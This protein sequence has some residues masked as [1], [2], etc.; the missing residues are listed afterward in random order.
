MWNSAA[1]WRKFIGEPMTEYSFE[2]A[3]LR[4]RLAAFAWDYLVILVYVLVTAV[5][6]ITMWTTMGPFPQTPLWLLDIIA[7][8]TMVLPVGLYFVLQECS[9]RQATWGKRRMGLQVML[10]DGR[11]LSLWRAVVRTAVKFL[12]WQ[13]AHI[14]IYRLVGLDEPPAWTTYGLILLWILVGAYLL[15]I[16]ATRNHQAPYDWLA[17]SV[18][19]IESGH[20]RRGLLSGS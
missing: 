9:P 13:I 2:Y 3:G 4:L 12:P 6:G 5:I 1:K 20:S 7:F 19:I 8:A 16:A 17:G 18:V 14:V 10:V 15:S 11:P